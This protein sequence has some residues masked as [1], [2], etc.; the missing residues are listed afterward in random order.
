MA[1]HCA[2]VTASA[3]SLSLR[4]G[5]AQWTKI[6]IVPSAWTAA[7]NSFFGAA[8]SARSAAMKLELSSR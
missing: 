8:G 7:S 5:A 1:S 3:V 4:F 2:S 6:E